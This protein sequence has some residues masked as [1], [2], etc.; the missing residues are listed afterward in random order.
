MIFEPIILNPDAPGQTPTGDRKL[1][2][3]VSALNWVQRYV[4]SDLQASAQ[5][6]DVVAKLNAANEDA[7]RTVEAR[8]AFHDA[9]IAN[10]YAKRG[11]H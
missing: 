6:L 8:N 7:A 2:S 1:L 11:I 10:G 9:M 5:W 4:G 3:V